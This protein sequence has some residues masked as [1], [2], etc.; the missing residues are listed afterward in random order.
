MSKETDEESP[1][2]I[3]EIPDNI[4]EKIP[5]KFINSRVIVFNPIHA[6]YLYVKKS[7]LEAR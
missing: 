7:F 5:A 6:S 2:K 1:K 4:S 3:P